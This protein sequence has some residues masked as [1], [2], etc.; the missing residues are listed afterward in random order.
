MGLKA[1]LEAM[2]NTVIL[3]EP[4]LAAIRKLPLGVAETAIPRPPEEPPVAKGDPVTDVKTPVLGFI[5]KA[6]TSF[7]PELEANRK[8][9]TM[10]TPIRLE[11]KKPSPTPVPPV[12]NGDPA[13][14]LRVPLEA[15]EKPE[16]VLET[17]WSSLV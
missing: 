9:P 7:E 16:T 4:L 2:L 8:L 13:T 14:G 15:T 12:A 17:N 11:A 5:V 1:P 6:L 10:A 3:L